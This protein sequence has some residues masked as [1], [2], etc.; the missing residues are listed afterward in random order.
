VVT[1]SS[2]AEALE[3]L[4]RGG[5]TLVLSDQMM[6]AMS[7]TEL[8]RTVKATNSRMPVILISGMNEAPAGANFAD[9]FICKTGGPELLFS[10]IADV[11]QQYTSSK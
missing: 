2:G 5:I 11:L 3:L 9:R 7:G 6:P 1:A 4:D 10:T 8:T